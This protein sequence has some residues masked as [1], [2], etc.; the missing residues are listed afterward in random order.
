MT[1]PNPLRTDLAGVTVETPTVLA[2]GILGVTA[3]TLA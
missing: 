1:T 2:S 3:S